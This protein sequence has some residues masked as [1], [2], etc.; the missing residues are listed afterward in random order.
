MLYLVDVKGWP[1]L[2]WPEELPEFGRFPVVARFEDHRAAVAAYDGAAAAA[3]ER[4]RARRSEERPRA[5]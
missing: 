3:C 5:H 1:T 2:V 4:I